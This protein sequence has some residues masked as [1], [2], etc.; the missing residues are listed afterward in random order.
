MKA[1]VLTRPGAAATA[2]ELQV[3]PDQAP[4]P[5]EVAVDVVAFGLNYADVMA[6]KGS[7]KDAPPVPCVIGYEAAGHVVA[8]GAGVTEFQVGQRVAAFTR[9]G[10][11]ATR[12][13]TTVDALAAVPDG[14]SWGEALALTVQYCTAWHAAEDCV[15]LFPGDH[16]LVQAAAGGVGIALVQMA[17]R[18][19]CVVYGTAGSDSKLDYLRSIGVDHPINYNKEDW[20]AKIR[21]LRGDKGLDV[22]FDSLGGAEFK[23]GYKALGKGG[24]I[25]GFGNASRSQG[26]TNIL[27]DLK[28]LFGFGFYSPAFMLMDSRAMI[29]VNMLR[30]ADH[31]PKVLKACL[32]SCFALAAAGEFKP[33]VGAEYPAS[34]LVAA[35]GFLEGR[36]SMGKIIVKW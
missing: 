1:Y 31:R 22:V 25:V 11:Y 5:G 13:V 26:W 29:G 18:R 17:K 8:V 2:F 27:G 7:Y 28:T 34:E 4:G 10:G 24:R 32:N 36:K 33:L 21:S 16:V 23:R 14:L 6:R 15:K 3:L 35:H 12:V 20:A 30:V 19:G 9:F